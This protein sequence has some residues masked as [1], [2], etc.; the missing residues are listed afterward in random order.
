MFGWLSND[1]HPDGYIGDPTGASA[2]SGAEL[3]DHAVR[4]IGEQLA[5]ISAFDFGR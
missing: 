3:F 2:E 1:F 4:T 5:E